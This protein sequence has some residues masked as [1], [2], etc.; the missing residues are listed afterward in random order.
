MQ[1]PKS[2]YSG[3]SKAVL[4]ELVLLLIIVKAK[5]ILKNKNLKTL[6]RN[7]VRQKLTAMI[8]GRNKEAQ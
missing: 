4:I 3:Y 8:P 2:L 1:V 7:L 6:E 5:K